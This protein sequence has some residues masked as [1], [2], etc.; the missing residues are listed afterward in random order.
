M[1]LESEISGDTTSES[2]LKYYHPLLQQIEAEANATIFNCD[3]VA[4]TD[5][6]NALANV[7]TEKATIDSIT[8]TVSTNLDDCKAEA[9]ALQALECYAVQVGF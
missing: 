6:S 9:N 5:R 2:C 4:T 8:G 3:S 7:T 1:L